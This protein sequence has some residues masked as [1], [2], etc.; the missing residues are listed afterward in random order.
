MPS[1]F[2]VREVKIPSPAAQLTP[3]STGVK[4]I[5][6]RPS[7]CVLSPSSPEMRVA[8]VWERSRDSHSKEEI[9]P[10][11]LYR[12]RANAMDDAVS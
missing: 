9:V 6:F 4:G 1:A 12:D 11:T 8:G 10:C 5:D 3:S 7:H 2:L